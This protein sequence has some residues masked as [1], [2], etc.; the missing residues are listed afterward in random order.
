M[1]I[2]TKEKAPSIILLDIETAPLTGYAWEMFDARI[3]KVLEPTKIISVAWKELHDPDIKVKCIADYKGYKRGEV[4]DKQLIQDTWKIIDRA[5]ILIGHHSDSF[6]LKKLN[7]RFVYHGL[8][9]PS[10]YK[11]IDTKK[12]ASKYFAFDSNSLDN[13][14]KY[15]GIGEKVKNGGFD[16]WVSCI[17]QGDPKAWD[18]MKKYNAQDVVLL[19]K[20]YMKLRPFI[21]NHP[22]LPA[23]SG[24]LGLSCPTCESVNVQ[25]R[26]FSATRTGRKQRYSCQDCGAWSSGPYERV[27]EILSPEED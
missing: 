22:N 6:D 21:A 1:S 4:N 24:K 20:L 12:V 15:F 7:S 10:N 8:T 14:G 18:L 3:L 16:L 25:K 5:D 9:A 27:K 26:G 2:P 23:I 13:L 17:E 11:S 19:E